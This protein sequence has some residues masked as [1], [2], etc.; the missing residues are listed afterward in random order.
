MLL[1]M[2]STRSAIFPIVFLLMV[3]LTGCGGAVH[4][5]GASAIALSPPAAGVLAERYPGASILL[6]GFEQADS[7]GVWRTG[8]RVLIGLSF[9]RGTTRTDRLLMVELLEG[10]G[11]RPRFERR[12]GVFDDELKID[13]P[14]RATR[15]RLYEADGTPISDKRGQLAEIFLDYGPIEVAR[16]GGGYAIATGDR[17]A[18]RENPRPEIDLDELTPGVYG[19]MSLLAFGEGASDSPTLSRL[20]ERAVTMGQKFGLLFSLGRFEIRFGEVELLAAGAEP[21][22]GFVIGEAYDCEIRISIGKKEALSGRA[23]LV[24]TFAPLGLCGGIVSCEL[25]NSANPEIRASVVLL[26]AVR[27]PVVTN[28]TLTNAKVGG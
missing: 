12:V 28:N 9:L 4:V 3:A 11:K 13:S 22:P 19:M 14:T 10:P 21:V 23:V 8:D 18:P 25:V 2:R 1:S 5:T 16:V 17:D 15:L 20:V 6:A 7:V 26:G 27:G 24:P